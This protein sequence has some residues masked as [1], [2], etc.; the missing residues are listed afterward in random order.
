VLQGPAHSVV[1]VL[2]DQCHVELFVFKNSVTWT[3]KVTLNSLTIRPNFLSNM[4]SVHF[5]QSVDYLCD[6]LGIISAE[7]CW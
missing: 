7:Y 5:V 1:T 6:C 4:A 3:R 2:L